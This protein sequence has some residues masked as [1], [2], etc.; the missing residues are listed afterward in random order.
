[1]PCVP[2][3]LLVY[4]SCWQGLRGA[5]MSCCANRRGS[6]YTHRG[7]VVGLSN[8]A[9]QASCCSLVLVA[10]V[11]AYNCEWRLNTVLTGLGRQCPTQHQKWCWQHVHPRGRSC[12]EQGH[13]FEGSC[14]MCYYTVR[15][16]RLL[17]TSCARIHCK[18]LVPFR[19]CFACQHYQIMSAS[20]PH[21]HAICNWEL[22]SVP[23]S[24]IGLHTRSRILAKKG[25]HVLFLG[26]QSLEPHVEQER[27]SQR[28][29]QR[30]RI[31][32]QQQQR[33]TTPSSLS[34]AVWVGHGSGLPSASARWDRP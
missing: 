32:Q 28:Q 34:Q 18:L 33:H 24:P 15:G 21:I 7:G 8:C 29:T 6:L 27:V 31:R 25:Q 1:M 4:P 2:C 22:L 11:P 26:Q 3:H 17:R 14:K 20:N 13:Y 16:N 10:I 9:G 30:A 12:L 5:L 19:E 23:C